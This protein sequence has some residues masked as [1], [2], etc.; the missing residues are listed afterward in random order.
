MEKKKRNLFLRIL[1]SLL[2]FVPL[3]LIT[4]MI[5]GAIV[6][7]ISG[8]QLPSSQSSLSDAFLTGYTTAYNASAAFF[9]KHGGIVFIFQ[10]ILWLWL[11][12]SGRLPGTGGGDL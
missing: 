2:W 10:V 6:G 7:G 5:I 3:F 9:Q 12:I 11:S 8:A 1:F 4:N